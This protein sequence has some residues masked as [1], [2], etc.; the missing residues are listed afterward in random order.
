[1]Q[2]L[3]TAV[4]IISC[5]LLV[6]VVLLQS[7]KGAEISASFSGSS[8][9]IFG[10]SGGANFFTKFTAI[11]AGVFMLTSLGLTILGSQTKKSIFEG[12]AP[13]AAHPVASAAASAA[14]SPA[15]TAATVTGSPMAAQ[16]SVPAQAVPA[17]AQSVPTNAQ[18][19][20]GGSVANP[21]GAAPLSSPAGSH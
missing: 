17:N 7:G 15:A 13:T 8:Q 12:S 14:T 16:T 20:P 3:V 9:T 4:H 11:T 21:K 5:V 1:M 10:S 2:L 6:L 19:V 18:A